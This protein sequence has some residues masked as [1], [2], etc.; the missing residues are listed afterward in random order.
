RKRDLDRA[1]LLEVM[2]KVCDGVAYAHQRGIIHRDLKPA[3]VM[4]TA[5]DEP[6]IMDFGLAKQLEVADADGAPSLV[7]REGAIMGTPHYMPPEQASG[8]VSEIDVR[9]DVYTL[10][11]ILYELFTG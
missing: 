5:G 4:I 2:I 11:V 10:G 3:N 8:E 9:S 1:A 6:L 7:T